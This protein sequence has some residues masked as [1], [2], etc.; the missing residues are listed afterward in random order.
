MPEWLSVALREVALHRQ[1]LAALEPMRLFVAPLVLIVF[2][3]LDPFEGA[4]RN[5]PR[6]PKTVLVREVAKRFLQSP[7]ANDS[8]HDVP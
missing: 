7:S 6:R 8:S 1:E 4:K 3:E 2:G 5:D